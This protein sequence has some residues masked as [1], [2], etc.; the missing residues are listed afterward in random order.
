MVVV[1]VDAGRR[2]CDHLH[3]TAPIR[4]DNQRFLFDFFSFLNFFAA[5]FTWP[6]FIRLWLVASSSKKQFSFFLRPFQYPDSRQSTCFFSSFFLIFVTCSIWFLYDRTT[7]LIK[8]KRNEITSKRAR[9][10]NQQWN[11]RNSI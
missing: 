9:I 2:S 3:P 8:P 4:I 1:A 7:H 11:T 6:F 10:E 5:R